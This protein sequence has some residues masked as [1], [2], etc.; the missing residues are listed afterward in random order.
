MT[1]AYKRIITVAGYT[2]SAVVALCGTY[3]IMY[4]MLSA[5]VKY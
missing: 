3:Y 5:K 4:R 1:N 2:I